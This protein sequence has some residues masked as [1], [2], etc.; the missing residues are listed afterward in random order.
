MTYLVL[1]GNGMTEFPKGTTK[2]ENAFMMEA[3]DL[4]YNKLTKLPEDIA[5]N[6]P[7]L[8]GIDISYNSFDHFP[9][10][11]LD[12]PLLAR[13]FIRYQ[14]DENGNRCMDEWPTGIWKHLGLRYLLM[15][16]N[17]LGK[18]E[19][20]MPYDLFYL[21]ISDNPN[22]TINVSEICTYLY[23]GYMM[24]IY[25][26]TQDIRGCDTLELED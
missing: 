13:Y 8:T 6:M 20:T 15:A 14:S 3:I 17:D 16:G 18:I 2:G 4:S 9:F 1:S 21:E 10:E 5:R 12:M 19:D 23:Y 7:Y 26:K 25:D 11:P 24:L 22:I